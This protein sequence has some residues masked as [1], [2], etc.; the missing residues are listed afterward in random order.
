MRRRKFGSEYYTLVGGQVKDG[1]T[2][3]QTLCREVQEETGLTVVAAQ[4]IYYEEHP[5][6]YNEQYIYLCNVA[7]HA[8]IAIQ[9]GSEEGV[10]NRYDMNI[11]QP[12]WVESQAFTRLPFRTPQLQEAIVRALKKGFPKEPVKV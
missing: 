4:L 9:D 5:S 10:M 3:E 6:P 7:P 8:D 12:F 1:E 2:F 11:H